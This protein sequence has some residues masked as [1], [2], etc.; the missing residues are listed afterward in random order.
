MIT[1][2]QVTIDEVEVRNEKVVYKKK[3][4]K[5][6]WKTRTMTNSLSLLMSGCSC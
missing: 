2:V 3:I 6:G 4:R 1:N 5:M